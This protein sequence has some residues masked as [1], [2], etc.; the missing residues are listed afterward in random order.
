MSDTLFEMPHP[1]PAVLTLFAL[2]HNVMRAVELLG[3]SA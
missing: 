2:A 1:E 3:A